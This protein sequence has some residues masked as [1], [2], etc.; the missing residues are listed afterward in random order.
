[1]AFEMMKYVAMDFYK[2]DKKTIKTFL[3][4]LMV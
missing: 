3:D 2:I 4:R 1:M